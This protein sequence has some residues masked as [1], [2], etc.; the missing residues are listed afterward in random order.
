MIH[1]PTQYNSFN[2]LNVQLQVYQQ[3]AKEFGQIYYEKVG[4]F[5]TVVVSNPE[6]Y[7]KV[8]RSEGKYPNRREMEPVAFYRQ[9]KGLDLGLVNSWVVILKHPFYFPEE[10]RIMVD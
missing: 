8:I 2:F 7:S 1:N 5:H 6:E 9:Y 4:N 3:R 10:D